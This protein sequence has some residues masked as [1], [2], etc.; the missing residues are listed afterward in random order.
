MAL[1]SLIASGIELT[2]Q[3]LTRL[4]LTEKQ[5]TLMR[6]MIERK[7]NTPLTSSCGRLFDAVASLVL[8]RHTVDYEAQAAVELEGLADEDTNDPGYSFDFIELENQPLQLNPTPMWRA[9]LADLENSVSP[10][11]ISNS[12]H[13]GLARAWTEAAIHARAQTGLTTVA[14][15]GGVFHNRLFTKLVRRNLAGAGFRVLTHRLVSPGDGGLSYGQVAIAAA[16][17]Q[18]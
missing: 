7:I 5:S 13:A 14:L 8:S 16:Q 3:I 1:G 2:P 9:I 11:A 10:Q 4:N 17:L 12:F 18:K 6:Q 15:S